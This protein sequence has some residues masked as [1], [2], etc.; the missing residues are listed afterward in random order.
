M[1]E[2]EDMEGRHGPLDNIGMQN[3][4]IICTR[5]PIVRAGGGQSVGC[6]FFCARGRG[7]RGGEMVG[8]IHTARGGME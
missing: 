4:T 8:W 3:L 6:M 2:R 5:W 1:Q 7:R